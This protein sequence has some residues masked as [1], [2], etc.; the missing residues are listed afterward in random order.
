MTD[1]EQAAPEATTPS[2]DSAEATVLTEVPSDSPSDDSGVDWGET[3]KSWSDDDAAEDGEITSLDEAPAET[4]PQTELPEVPP[5]PAIAEV[6]QPAPPPEPDL[7]PV[8]EEVVEPTPDPEVEPVPEQ[9]EMPTLSADDRTKMRNDWVAS[10]QDSYKLSEGQAEKMRLEPEKALPELAANMHASVMESVM[11]LVSQTLPSAIEQQLN[12]TKVAK[13]SDEAFFGQWPELNK[14]EYRGKLVELGKI[15]R[16]NNPQ[17]TTKIFNRD[18]GLLGWQS[19]GLPMEQLMTRG[20]QKT[21]VAPAAQPTAQPTAG[22]APVAST[23]GAGPVLDA[24]PGDNVF[25]DLA[26]AWDLE[27]G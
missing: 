27:E 26:T 9:P 14:P 11:Q 5:E 22:Y 10:L 16:Q 1:L 21:A 19:L 24:V 3:A 15:Y 18:V 4:V 2:A 12:A 8:V 20:E 23:P 6:E 13:S 7:P 25:G 17:A